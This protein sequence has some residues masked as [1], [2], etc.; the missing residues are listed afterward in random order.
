MPI[1]PGIMPVTSVAGIKRMAALNGSSL[2][3]ELMARLARVEG[4][5]KAV[6]EIGTAWALAQCEELVR[7]G[8]PGIHFYTLN[9]KAATRSILSQ[10]R[11]G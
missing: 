3:A 7:R 5:D 8:A 10:L 11:G 1:V 9:R 6:E 4:D 2:P